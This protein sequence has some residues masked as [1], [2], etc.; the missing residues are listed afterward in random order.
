MWKLFQLNFDSLTCDFPISE[1][2][3]FSK[4]FYLEFYARPD[5]LSLIDSFNSMELWNP[6]IISKK[7]LGNFKSMLWQL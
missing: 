6:E 1:F 5:K 2:W 7:I 4:I 3:F